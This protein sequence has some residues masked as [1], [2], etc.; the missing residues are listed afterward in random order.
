V[1]TPESPPTQ[2]QDTRQ[3]EFVPPTPPQPTPKSEPTYPRFS[4]EVVTV[5][6]QGQVV[7]RRESSAP[8]Q[9]VDLGKGVTLEIVLIPEGTFIMGSPSTEFERDK[10]EGPQRQVTLAEFWMGKYPITQAQWRTV[11]AFPKIELDLDPNPSNFKGD[12]RPVEQVTW[13][14]AIEFCGRL[15]AHS[16][17]TYT[18][19]SEAQWEYAC[20]AGTTRAF[21]FGETLTTELAN[22]NGNYTYGAEHQ[23]VYRA[24]T[25]EVGRFRPNAFGLYEMYGNV[26]EWCLDRYHASYSSWRGRAPTDGSAWVTDGDN[27]LRLVR[28]GSWLNNPVNCRS[29]GR[30]CADPDNR[31]NDIGFRVVC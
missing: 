1:N 19:P 11:A 29:S 10:D 20:R 21:H 22:Y 25:T 17:Q 16:S 26:W 9:T 24:E 27:K 7:D 6:P 3:Q 5:N 2:P 12:N 23:G 13:H 8:Y 14:E 30:D 15:T 28:G 31:L 18:L 4:F